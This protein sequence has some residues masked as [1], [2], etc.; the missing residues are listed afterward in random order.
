MPGMMRTRLKIPTILSTVAI[1]CALPLG[2]IAYQLN[3]IRQ[4]HEF[5]RA[6]DVI[7]IDTYP[8]SAPWQ[9]SI[10]G[11]KS[12]GSLRVPSSDVHGA[13]RLFPE[14]T[15]INRSTGRAE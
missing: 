8:T 14:S 13:H 15:I 7:Y 4:R 12:P 2:W 6:G 1:I 11:E 3:W 9:V 5:L 10:F